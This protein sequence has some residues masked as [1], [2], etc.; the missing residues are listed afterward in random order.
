MIGIICCTVLLALRLERYI[1]KF[2]YVMKQNRNTVTEWMKEK[3]DVKM[4][5]K[6]DGR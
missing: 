3:N 6:Q 1:P 5:H 2:L 4:G